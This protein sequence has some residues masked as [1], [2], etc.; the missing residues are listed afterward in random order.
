MKAMEGILN[1]SAVKRF[2]FALRQI[3]EVEFAKEKGEEHWGITCFFILTA[4]ATGVTTFC[5]A[6]SGGERDSAQYSRQ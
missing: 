6:S 2:H 5:S 3:H 4:D 1:R